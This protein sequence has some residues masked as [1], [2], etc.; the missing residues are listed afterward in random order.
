MRGPVYS[1]TRA[2][3]YGCGG[4][5]TGTVNGGGADN[6]FHAC[7]QCFLVGGMKRMVTV[8]SRS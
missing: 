1:A 4:V 5:A 7:M 2:H 3:M 8:D 6:V